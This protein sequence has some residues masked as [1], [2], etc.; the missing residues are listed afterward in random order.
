MAPGTYYVRVGAAPGYIVELHDNVPCIAEDCQSD[1]GT[2]V[3]VTAGATTT[4]DFALAR[5]S[6]ITGT[7]LR[8]G[9][10]AAGF[11]VNI[12]NVAGSFVRSTR[13]A[14]DGTYVATGLSPG[15]YFARAGSKLYSGISC[16]VEPGARCAPTTAALFQALPSSLRL[17][18][19]HRGSISISIRRV[20]SGALSR[21]RG[22]FA[23]ALRVGRAHSSVNDEVGRALTLPS[24]E[25]FLPIEPGIYTV[26]TLIEDSTNLVNEW[27]GDVC[28]GCRGDASAGC[29]RCRSGRHWNRLL[30]RTRRHDFGPCDV[31]VP[32]VRACVCCR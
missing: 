14:A 19:P 27:Y 13:T 30:A 8:G 31:P 29:R 24:G 21:K 1:V 4:V 28:V 7:V 9:V 3:L 17:R 22:P 12:Y 2:P 16:P 20:P 5:G 32:C 11:R 26:R 25:Y 23:D 18:L 15:T 6:S 10:P